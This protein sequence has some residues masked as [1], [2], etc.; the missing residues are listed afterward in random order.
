MCNYE[1]MKSSRFENL[2]ESRKLV[3]LKSMQCPP[4]NHVNALGELCVPQ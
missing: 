3:K 4:E 2:A 1:K